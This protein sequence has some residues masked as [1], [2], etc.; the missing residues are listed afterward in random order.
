MLKFIESPLFFRTMIEVDY[1]FR[2]QKKT[3]VY[4][5]LLLTVICKTAD[6]RTITYS[7]MWVLITFLANLVA[8]ALLKFI[9]NNE[10][11]G[12]LLTIF[13]N[14]FFTTFMILFHVVSPLL[15][16]ID[17]PRLV[18]YRRIFYFDSIYAAGSY[19]FSF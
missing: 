19:V 2:W 12:N 14:E 3:F 10:I 4:Y 13:P 8:F 6:F 7:L 11:T 5:A 9:S 16:Y 18:R 17:E 15:L 1:F